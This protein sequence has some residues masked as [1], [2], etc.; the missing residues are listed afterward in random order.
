[1]A[2]GFFPPPGQASFALVDANNFNV[3]CER[4]FDYRLRDRLVVAL[5]NN[6]GCC[7]AHSE[8]AKA[9]GIRMGQPFFDVRDLL[10]QK[11]SVAL[12]SNHPPLCRH[13]TAADSGHWPV[14]PGTGDLLLLHRR[15][16]SAFF[17]L[18]PLGSDR[19]RAHHAGASVALD[20]V[21]G[22]G[23]FRSDQDPGKGRQPEALSP[24]HPDRPHGPAI[25]L[26]PQT[27]RSEAP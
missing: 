20:G 25:A 16:L 10:E 2:V 6:D 19:P 9:L 5:S 23:G 3:S 22:E 1:M 13:E 4:V 18:R 26:A 24:H 21:T 15:E 11:Q 14:L 17:R 8:E 27:P 12:S 7:V